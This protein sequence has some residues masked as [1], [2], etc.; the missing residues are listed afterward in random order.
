MLPWLLLCISEQ[1]QP[2]TGV[3][4]TQWLQ[5]RSW[6]KHL[7]FWVFD[8]RLSKRT[9]L[10]WDCQHARCAVK[11]WQCLAEYHDD[12]VRANIP[13]TSVLLIWSKCAMFLFFF[14]FGRL[15][16][17]S[18]SNSSVGFALAFSP[19]HPYTRRTQRLV[20]VPW[21]DSH[22]RASQY[23]REAASWQRRADRM[24]AE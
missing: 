8:Q 13:L 19:L 21:C 2:F 22:N 4:Q 5:C 10:S 15:L 20:W 24:R 16:V 23:Q 1:V 9:N 14:F 18:F 7:S 3:Y 11:L 6:G 12:G 17:I